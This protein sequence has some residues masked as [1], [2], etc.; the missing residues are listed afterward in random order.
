MI[1]HLNRLFAYDAWANGEVLNSL[2][3][4]SNLPARSVK[5]LAHILS[6]ERLW[7]ERIHAQKQS[8][9]VWPEFTLQRC[10]DEAREVASLWQA[11]LRGMNAEELARLVEYKNSKGQSW[12]SQVQDILLHVITHSAYHRGQIAADMRAAGNTPAYT[13]YIHA[14]RNELV[15]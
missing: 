9:A 13:D 3:A 15:G 6:A 2:R 4:A 11:S 8:L 7:Y 1:E 5:L 10:E 12:S 14:V